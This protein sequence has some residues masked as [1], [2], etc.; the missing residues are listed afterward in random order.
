MDG[1][2]KINMSEFALG[3]KSSLTVY[4][5]KSKRPKSSANINYSTKL[6]NGSMSVKNG[7]SAAGNFP[8]RQSTTPKRASG[9]TPR[10]IQGNMARRQSSKSGLQRPRT[11]KASSKNGGF[12][13]SLQGGAGSM[14]PRDSSQGRRRGRA[15]Q[16]HSRLMGPDGGYRDSHSRE[17]S[18]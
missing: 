7:A 14:M 17:G 18:V 16:I 5:K 10:S 3:M 2:A 9:M 13:P 1:D 12:K 11:G 8:I 6:V 4:A 15:A